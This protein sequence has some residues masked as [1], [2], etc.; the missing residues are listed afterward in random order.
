MGS[1]EVYA[2]LQ[3]QLPGMSNHQIGDAVGLAHGTIS[4]LALGNGIGIKAAEWLAAD[5]AKWQPLFEEA[6]AQVCKS[7]KKKNMNKKKEEKK[8]HKLSALPLHLQQWAGYVS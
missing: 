3:E 5:D 1:K 7:N 6:Q 8:P 4:N 2:A